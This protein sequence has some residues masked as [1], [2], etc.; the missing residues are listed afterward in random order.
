MTKRTGVFDVQLDLNQIVLGEKATTKRKPKSN[1]MTIEKA[2]QTIT[3]QMEVSGFRERTMSDYNLHMNHF[4]EI[5]GSTYL[6]E[7]TNVTI[8][9]WLES[10]NVSNSTKLIRLKCLKA[11]LSKFFDNGWIKQKFWKSINIKVD[12]NV[13]KGAKSDEINILLSLIDLNT[14]IGLRDTVAILTLYK[15]GIRIGTLGQLEEKHIDF[16]NLTLNLDGSILKNHKF[17]KLPIDEQ[18]ANLLQVLIQQNNKIKHLYSQNN[19]LVFVSQKGTSLS[20]KSTN[21]AISKQLHKYAI[22]YDLQNINPHAIRRGFAKNLLNKGANLALISKA[23][24]H[25]SLASTTFYLSLDEEEV[26]TN[27][28]DFL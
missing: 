12:K 10:M 5:T 16:E 24:G 6:N 14:F 23:L 28:R 13:K 11:I 3:K 19:S 15:T 27:L 2:V 1:L 18:L 9:Q 4:C 7:I 25:S 20:T 17:L 22:K 26:A 21:N 8:Y